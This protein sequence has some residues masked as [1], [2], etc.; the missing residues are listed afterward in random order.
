MNFSNWR[1]L[2]FAE[3]EKLQLLYVAAALFFITLVTWLI[4]LYLRPKITHGSK[5]P[6][7]GTMKFWFGLSVV[8][9]LCIFAYARPFL[10]K[11]EVVFKRGNA[12]VVFVVDYSASMFLKDTGWAK[13]D[14]VSR[15]IM[16]ALLGG[17]IKKGDRAAILIFGKMFSP[18]LPLTGDLGLLA[19][20]ADKI[21]RPDTLLNN[22]LFWGSAVVTTF[23]RAHEILDRQDMFAEFH[24]ESEN[25]RP[26]PKTNRLIIIFSDG[27]FFNYADEEGGKELVELE[28]KNLQAELQELRKRN[29][30]VYS[31]GIGTRSGARLTDILKDYKKGEEYDPALEEELR[32]QV[33]RLNMTNLENISMATDGKTFSIEDFRL[34]AG[35]FIQA[36]ID[37]YRSTF[38]EPVPGDDKEELWQYF[39]LGALAV[40]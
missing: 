40:F 18:T 16:Q 39:L 10:A 26:K 23:K 19:T 25:W 13:I 35:G 15:E 38:V 34:D 29:I 22:D 31:V 36:S 8:L 28:K 9:S 33:S 7:L 2:H 20:E 27:D 21:G 30:S 14:I 24:K 6:I 4:K 17:I 32:G 37:K 11:G 5:Y 12:E 1:D 3:P